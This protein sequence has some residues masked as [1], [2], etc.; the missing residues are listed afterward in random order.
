MIATIAT[1]CL[2]AFA[3]AANPAGYT[4]SLGEPCDMVSYCKSDL[5]CTNGVFGTGKCV[6]GELRR[7]NC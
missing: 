3:P 2:A 1:I 6:K 5:K 4:H 7:R